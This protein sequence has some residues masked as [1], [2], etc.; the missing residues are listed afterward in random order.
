VGPSESLSRPSRR[1]FLIAGGTAVAAAAGI[2]AAKLTGAPAL[3][4][5]G[6]KS[7]PRITGG[8]VNESA[9]LGHRL[10]DGAAMP[11]PRRTVRVPVVIVGG[12]IAGLSAAWQLERN[13]F[14]DYVLLE[15]EREAGGNSRGGENAV[16]RYPWAA[17]YVP[18]PGPRATLVR[19]LFREL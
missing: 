8:W 11:A 14:H 1:T 6:R 12:G 16:S 19:E 3:L 2:V 10:R 5:L 9:A 15:M 13:G 18:V 7:G 4:G 17:H